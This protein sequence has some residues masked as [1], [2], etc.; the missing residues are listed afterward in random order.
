MNIK[1][2]TKQKSKNLAQ[3]NRMPKV[4]QPAQS[5]EDLKKGSNV[6]SIPTKS[7]KMR[8]L[9]QLKGSVTELS[10]ITLPIFKD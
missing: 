3:T 8:I 4:K 6:L 1:S 5:N 10:D 7:E 9:N 2:A